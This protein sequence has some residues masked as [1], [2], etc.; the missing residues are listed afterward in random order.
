[1]TEHLSEK[2][3]LQNLLTLAEFARQEEGESSKV[4]VGAREMIILRAAGAQVLQDGPQIG[5]QCHCTKVRL[6]GFIFEHVYL[7]PK[8][9]PTGMPC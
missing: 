6:N 4:L 8:L 7:Y 3:S 5:N 1:M 2:L 9:E